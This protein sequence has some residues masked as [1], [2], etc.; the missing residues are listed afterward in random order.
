[1]C[2]VSIMFILQILLPELQT[3]IGIIHGALCSIVAYCGPSAST[4]HHSL[5]ICTSPS[6]THQRL[7]M[8]LR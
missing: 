3:A 6:A 1:M 4:S 2:L 7:D 5:R 8:K